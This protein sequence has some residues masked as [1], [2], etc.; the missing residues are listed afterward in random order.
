MTRPLLVFVG[1]DN[2]G[3]YINVMA[4]AVDKYNVDRIVLIDI[5]DAPVEWQVDY[6]KFVM[7]RLP[8]TLADLVEGR[9]EGEIFQIPKDFHTYENLKR[10]FVK[11]KT[12][13]EVN[14]QLLREAMAKIKDDYGTETIV[15]LTC[16]P[17]RIAIDILTACLAV[18]LSN[19]MLFELK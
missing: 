3:P 15:D 13:D 1:S 11:S 17:K 19:V 7:E 8:K 18:G 14:Y 12:T 16:I 10:I 5:V 2:V 6:E 9:Y 4:K